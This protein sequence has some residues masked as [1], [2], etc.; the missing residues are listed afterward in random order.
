[1]GKPIKSYTKAALTN[2]RVN[3][4]EEL[5]SEDPVLERTFRGHNG[6][7]TSV[8]FCPSMKKLVSSS[9]DATI[10]LWSFK[11][12]LRAFKYIGHERGHGVMDAVFSPSG[13]LIA[14]GSKDK[15]IRIWEATV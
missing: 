5:D 2:T 1:M 3:N 7:I 4:T 9:M 11:P 6:T 12:N 14:T 15:T 8:D 10:M 13:R